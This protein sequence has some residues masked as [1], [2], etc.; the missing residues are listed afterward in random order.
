MVVHFKIVGV[1]GKKATLT[2]LKYTYINWASRNILS[3]QPIV[4]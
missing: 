1:E 4:H 2:P 3:D